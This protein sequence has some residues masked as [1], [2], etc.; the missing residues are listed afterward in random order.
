MT[1]DI[2][3]KMLPEL[4]LLKHLSDIDN[5]TDVIFDQATVDEILLV[6]HSQLIKRQ[7]N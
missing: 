2:T 1:R 3:P 5:K 4:P 7:S 6:I